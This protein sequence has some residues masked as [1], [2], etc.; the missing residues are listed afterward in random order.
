MYKQIVIYN[1]MKN[2]SETYRNTLKTQ[3]QNF[4]RDILPLLSYSIGHLVDVITCKRIA[5]S[6]MKV[7]ILEGWAHSEGWLLQVFSRDGDLVAIW[8]WTGGVFEVW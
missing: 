8:R 1:T 7:W 3:E 2:Y 5:H 6:G 4:R